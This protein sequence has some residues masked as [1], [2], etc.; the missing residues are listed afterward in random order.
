G[1]VDFGLR[2][3]GTSERYLAPLSATTKWRTNQ[4]PRRVTRAVRIHSV[5]DR[6]GSADDE[7]GNPG[8]RLRPRP[9]NR[10]RGGAGPDQQAAGR[11]PGRRRDLGPLAVLAPGPGA[12]RPRGGRVRGTAGVDRVRQAVRAAV[13]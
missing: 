9:G 2:A 1:S 4:V 6:K 5:F 12:G 7:C 8:G 11:S 3:A 10:A 13:P